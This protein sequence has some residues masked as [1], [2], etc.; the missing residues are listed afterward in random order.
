MTKTTE[1]PDDIKEMASMIINGLLREEGWELPDCTNDEAKVTHRLELRLLNAV[2]KL[3][4]ARLKKYNKSS[5]IDDPT[6]WTLY[7][8]GGNENS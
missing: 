6:D 1:V 3:F 2:N 8:G 4:E 7:T 5:R